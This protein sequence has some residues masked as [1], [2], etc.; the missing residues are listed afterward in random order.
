MKLLKFIGVFVLVVL[1]VGL[2]ARNQLIKMEARRLIAQQTGFGLEI[3]SL[4]THLW[5]TRVEL[6]N[7]VV[8]NPPDFP[9]STAF[10][11]R[12]VWVDV[13]PWA[14][15]RRETHLTEMVLDVPRV[16]V[17]R[18]EKGDTNL[19]RLSAASRPA[20]GGT[21]SAPAPQP[22]KPEGDAKPVPGPTPKESKPERPFL[23]D[24]MRLKIG[25]VEYHDYRA[26]DAPAVTK[27]NL[28]VDREHRDLRSTADIGNLLIAGVMESAAT[29]LFGDVG[30]SLQKVA[31]DEQLRA[32][33]K[34]IGKDLKRAFK[35]LL[36]EPAAEE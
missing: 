20:S 34:K 28:N 6:E 13:D 23:I 30:R 22:R 33:V 7:V 8:R 27:L 14:L 16:V 31:E 4:K 21:P 1:V 19:K 12:R 24:R 26:P 5:S 17:V 25:T 10:E 36:Q 29:Q 11:I 15:F 3:G 32:E 2:L 35:G 9:E 18:N